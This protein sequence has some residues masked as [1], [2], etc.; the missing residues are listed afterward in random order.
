MSYQVFALKWRPQK[1]ADVVGQ[2]HVT[3]P[4][5]NAIRENRVPHAFLLT[6]GRGVGKTTTARI[7]A[8][9][10]VCERGP[11]AEPCNE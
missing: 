5:Q 8:K 6:G 7:L 4:L 11:A 1:F 2:E 9:A 10:L 3:R